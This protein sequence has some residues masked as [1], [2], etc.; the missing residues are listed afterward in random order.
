MEIDI[1]NFFYSCAPIDFSAS[2]FE[3]GQDAGRITWQAALEETRDT[4][5]L[6]T[7]EEKEAFRNFISGFWS[8]EE[9]DSWNDDEL[10]ALCIQFIAGEMREPV[11]FELGTDTTD[12]EW[13]E[14]ARQAQEG[15][16]SGR[17]FRAGDRVFFYVGS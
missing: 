11:G 17:L 4:V 10:N 5:L 6:S 3:I 12:E 8:R 1:T 7:D 16:I 2:A 9:V 13:E 15:L 14:Y